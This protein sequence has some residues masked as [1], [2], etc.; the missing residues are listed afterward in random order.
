VLPQ[1]ADS[2]LGGA[3]IFIVLFYMLIRM[4]MNAMRSGAPGVK[5]E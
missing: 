1:I 3:A 2:A 5:M 4:P